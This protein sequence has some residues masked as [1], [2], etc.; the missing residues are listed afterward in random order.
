MAYTKTTWT[1]DAPPAINATNLNK[2]E[3]GIYNAQDTADINA[4]DITALETLLATGYM[5]V[6]TTT[7][8][9]STTS[10]IADKA[11]GSVSAT[12]TAIS[13][14]DMYIA[15]FLSSNYGIA[16]ANPTISGTSI[17]AT[18]MNVS[19]SSHTVAARYLIIGLKQLS[20]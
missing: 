7:V 10:S 4:A 8:S 18:V 9:A 13:G 1:N 16:T 17:S 20:A 11:T 15:A 3:Q 2:I 19:G 14:A 6:G 5:I 12:F